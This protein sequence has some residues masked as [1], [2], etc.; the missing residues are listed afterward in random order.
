MSELTKLVSIGNHKIAKN[1][2]IFNLSSANNCPC[3]D[4]CSFGIS[5]KCYA[6]K[7]ERMYPSV[8]PYRERQHDYWEKNTI[9][10][11]I[12]DFV[13]FFKSHP[14][15][16]YLR[17]NEAGDAKRYSDFLKMDLIACALLKECGVKT[18]T[19]THNRQELL[20]YIHLFDSVKYLV[21]NLSEDWKDEE[22][23]RFNRFH[24]VKQFTPFE[25]Q[26]NCDAGKCMQSCHSCAIQHG[27]RIEVKI[28]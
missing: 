23:K 25:W 19:Y 12:D 15:L 21:I 13:A 6:L 20:T 24:A 22:L 28:H 7:A 9:A 8:L 2:A 5:G 3:K 10:K 27:N 4:Y 16:Q 18:Y 11:I 14:K 26:C 1:T 17:L